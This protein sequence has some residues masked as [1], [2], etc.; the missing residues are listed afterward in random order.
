MPGSRFCPMSCANGVTS[1]RT[2]RY[3]T[4]WSSPNRGRPPAAR[5]P[6]ASPTGSSSI[7]TAMLGP[8]YDPRDRRTGPEGQEAVDG[9]AAMKRNRFISSPAPLR[10]LANRRPK[11]AHWRAGRAT[12][13]TAPN[14]PSTPSSAPTT[15]CGASRRR[16]GCPSTTCLP[17]R[18]TTAPANRSRPTRRSCSPRR[19]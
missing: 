12:P 16:S 10:A 17:A 9:H 13:P 15:S 4:N 5:R 14:S 19:P 7:S 18:S 11:A 6:A 3:P 8:A 1:T 2:K